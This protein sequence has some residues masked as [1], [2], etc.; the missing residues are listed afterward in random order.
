[1]SRCTAVDGTLLALILG[2][3]TPETLAISRGKKLEDEVRKTVEKKIGM[4]IEK[5]GLCIY[6]TYIFIYLRHSQ[7][8][9]VPQ[10]GL[11]IRPL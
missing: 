5:C 11:I 1:M 6:T 9:L 3:R 8:L 10:L 4:K 7:W 2:A